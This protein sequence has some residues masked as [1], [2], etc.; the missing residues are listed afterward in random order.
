[1]SEPLEVVTPIRVLIVDDSSSIRCL[2]SE[3]LSSDPEIQVVGVAPDAYIARNKLISLAPDLMILDVEMPKMDGI[4]FLKKVMQH[5]PTP[6]IIF[7]SITKGNT[8]LVAKAYE[9][10]ALEVVEKRAVDSPE[11]I[12]ELARDFISLIKSLTRSKSKLLT[13]RK[14]TVRGEYKN[15]REEGTPSSYSPILAI[16]SSTGGTEA[17][18]VFLSQ[19]PNDLPGTLIVQHMPP[20]FTKTYAQSLQSLCSFEVKEAED[21]DQVVAGRV[22]LAPGNYHMELD[23]RGAQYYVTLHQHSKLH[24]VRPAADFL[25]RSVARYAGP[26]SI[27]VV[28]TGMGRDGADGLLSM[29]RAGSFNIAQDENTS[30]VFGMPKA[31]IDLAAIHRTLPLE[32]IADEVMKHFRYKM[33]AS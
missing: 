13:K 32:R 15:D 29:K 2:L 3:I 27:G 17:L 31:A 10:G 24:G 8:E 11:K 21:G 25:M 7:S 30:V 5:F 14:L 18:K 26:N 20:M 19:M 28:L 6:T 4:T 9:A 33:K 1:M 12:Q 16:A 23:R 22:L